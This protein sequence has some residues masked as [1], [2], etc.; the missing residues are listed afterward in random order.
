MEAF[1]AYSPNK[2]IKLTPGKPETQCS[3]LR[4][5]WKAL[6]SHNFHIRRTIRFIIIGQPRSYR[7]SAARRKRMEQDRLAMTNA[8]KIDKMAISRIRC[9]PSL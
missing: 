8:I 9:R 3:R 2:M 5:L 4:R 7:R 1:S 6:Y